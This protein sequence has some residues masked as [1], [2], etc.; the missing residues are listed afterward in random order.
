M[1]DGEYLE[2]YNNLSTIYPRGSLGIF[3]CFLL[4]INPRYTYKQLLIL[5]V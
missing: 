4:H 1:N 3:G 2:L 5:A